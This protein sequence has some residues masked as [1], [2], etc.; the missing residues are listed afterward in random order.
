MMH[1]NSVIMAEKARLR[2][3]AGLDITE[4]REKDFNRGKQRQNAHRFYQEDGNAL[5]FLTEK[6]RNFLLKKANSKAGQLLC[7]YH[8]G[9]VLDDAFLTKRSHLFIPGSESSRELAPG[10]LI[11][12]R[13]KVRGV[14]GITGSSKRTRG[15]AWGEV[16]TL[17]NDEQKLTYFKVKFVPGIDPVFMH[18]ACL[19]EGSRAHLWGDGAK[20]MASRLSN[21]DNETWKSFKASCRA[22]SEAVKAKAEAAKATAAKKPGKKAGKLVELTTSRKSKKAR[23]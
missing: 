18:E 13:N 21:V 4:D 20:F 8:Q 17:H 5:Q 10:Q 16:S 6:K 7:E 14:N 15:F 3:K 23:R 19:S 12:R 1:S 2:K 9:E 11:Y 22:A